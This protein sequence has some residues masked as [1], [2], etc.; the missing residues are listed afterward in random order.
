MK[1]VK[2]TM[3]ISIIEL[4]HYYSLLQNYIYIFL[5]PPGG[6]NEYQYSGSEDEKDDN[7]TVEGEGPS[8]IQQAPGNSTLRRDFQ[9]IQ[10]G[11]RFENKIKN[12]K[13]NY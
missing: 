1:T 11:N 6:E 13:R 9:K 5:Y 4:L 12:N 2:I 8:S 10:E 7:P 3:F